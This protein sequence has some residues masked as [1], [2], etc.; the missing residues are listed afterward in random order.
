MNF[1]KNKLTVTGGMEDLL[2][3]ISENYERVYPCE[4]KDI[5]DYILFFDRLFPTPDDFLISREK[6]F[7]WRLKNWSTP[8]PAQ[9][10]Q[11]NTLKV[12]Y[13]HDYDYT[14]Y[15]L[16]NLNNKFNGYLFYRFFNELD[17]Y[18]SNLSP[19]ENELT[20]E[21]ETILCPPFKIIENWIRRYNGLTLK[22]KLDYYDPEVEFAGNIHFDYNKNLYEL[23]H[24]SKETDDEKYIEYLLKI[25]VDN[26]ER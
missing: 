18:S 7:E 15:Y 22:F 23:E 10:E 11:V 8:S 16:S 3:F 21:F 4:N 13:K 9:Y 17:F 14:R 20:C 12:L 19:D 25:G 24:F 2:I 6:T 26:Y 1:V 5:S